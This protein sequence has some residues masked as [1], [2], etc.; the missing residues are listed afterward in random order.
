LEIERCA[1]LFKALSAR[2]VMTP[3]VGGELGARRFEIPDFAIHVTSECLKASE[4]QLW[5]ESAL[6]PIVPA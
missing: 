4:R 2:Y 5:A 6:H 3:A 1:A